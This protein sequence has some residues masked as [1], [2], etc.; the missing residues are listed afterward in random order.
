M[1]SFYKD[2]VPGKIRAHVDCNIFEDFG[3]EV[4]PYTYI[5]NACNCKGV[6][7]SGISKDIKIRYPNV[8][9][10]YKMFCKN[11][12]IRIGSLATSYL[13]PSND[14]CDKIEGII[15]FPTKDDWKNPSEIDFLIKGFSYFCK[16]VPSNLNIAFPLLGAGA[17][18]IDPKQS[19]DLM[20]SYLVK[21]NGKGKYGIYC[22]SEQFIKSGL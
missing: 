12:S 4:T 10:E 16:N 15:H 6:A 14:I 22:T 5:V 8:F 1:N 9:K 20:I 7:G 11:G 13:P 21:Q 18:K 2:I 3:E 19:M 17:G